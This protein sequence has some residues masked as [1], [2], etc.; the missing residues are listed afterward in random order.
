MAPDLG[1]GDLD[2]PLKGVWHLAAMLDLGQDRDGTVYR[3]NTEGTRYVVDYCL[4]RRLPLYYCS[5]AYTLGRNAYERSK[6]AAEDM[7][8]TSGVPAV[9]FKPGILIAARGNANPRDTR[10]FYQFVRLMAR[11]HHRAELVRRK[12]EGTLRLP[13]IEPLLRIRGQP[14][15][16]AN[17]LPVD[18][19]AQFMV[20]HLAVGRTYYVT[21]PKPPTLA[22]LAEWVG[23][24]ILLRI[25]V[26]P[27]FKA[28]PIEA[29]LGRLTRSFNPYL[30][31][32]VL[33][34]D[35]PSGEPPVTRDLIQ[36]SITRS[37]LSL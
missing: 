37:L 9:V 34:S 3:T 25:Q 22:E 7:I 30:W 10:G 36:Q 6:A 19:A 13:V 23:E 27:D 16:F 29:V 11:V 4:R 28:T 26:H 1:L 14:E 32:D 15:A 20:N 8:R 18:M 17:L 21:N 33:Q 35:L 2:L 31:G 12:I 24:A 5:T